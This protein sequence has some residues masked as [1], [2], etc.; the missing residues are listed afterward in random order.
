MIFILGSR[1]SGKT[2]E[3]VKAAD[4]TGAPIVVSNKARAAH[5]RQCAIDMGMPEVA[6]RVVESGRPRGQ[7]VEVCV[8]DAELILERAVGCPVRVA[9][10]DT[11]RIDMRKMTSHPSRRPRTARG[12][13]GLT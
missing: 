3:L 7:F 1:G 13:G 2:R 5:L 6:V 4:R 12:V 11:G 9:T 10:F 8:D